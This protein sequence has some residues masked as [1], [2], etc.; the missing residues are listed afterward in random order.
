MSGLIGGQ[1]YEGQLSGLIV[2]HVYIEQYVNFHLC[3]Y[4]KTAENAKINIYHSHKDLKT[5][6][7]NVNVEKIAYKNI[8]ARTLTFLAIKV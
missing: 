8:A 6:K 4:R 1:P 3:F 7:T 5:W 2:T